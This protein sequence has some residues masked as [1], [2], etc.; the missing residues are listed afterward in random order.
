MLTQE[1]SLPFGADMDAL[2]YPAS[3]MSDSR[4][5]HG[6]GFSFYRRSSS[7]PTCGRI[8]SK[9]RGTGFMVAVAQSECYRRNIAY[10]SL[11]RERHFRKHAVFIRDLAFSYIAEPVGAFDFILMEI[12]QSYLTALADAHGWE[13]TVTLACNNDHIDPVLSNLLRAALPDN[14]QQVRSN[15]P[16]VDHL[17]SA[18][19]IYLLER[20]SGGPPRVSGRRKTLLSQRQLTSVKNL[21][22]GNLD[23]VPPWKTWQ[24]LAAYRAVTSYMRSR[25][26]RG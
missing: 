12:S 9:A 5:L 18:I 23:D 11:M 19:G 21:M 24:T 17:G 22:L 16:F 7:E 8:T 13:R 3:D 2:G 15:E 1:R 14:E 6:D 26:R 25:K 10:R 20:Y 4:E